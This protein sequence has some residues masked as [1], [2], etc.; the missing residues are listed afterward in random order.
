MSGLQPK[1]LECRI[2]VEGICYQNT[3]VSCVLV[4]MGLETN[5]G[6]KEIYYVLPEPNKMRT[7]NVQ[8][9]GS[10]YFRNS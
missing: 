7:D 6:T 4:K 10:S 8:R 9:R 1:K 3:E 5:L 2:V